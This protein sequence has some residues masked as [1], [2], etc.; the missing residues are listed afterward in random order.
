MTGFID[1]LTHS[2]LRFSFMLYIALLVC[3]EF[4]YRI[5]DHRRRVVPERADEGAGLIVTSILG[6]L[7]FI[8]ALTLSNASTRYSERQS[9]ALIEANAISTAWLQA[10]AVGGERA[11]TLQAALERYME[12]RHDYVSAHRSDPH[13]AEISDET[14]ALQNT[15]WAEL[16]AITVTSAT[17]TVSSLMNA[18]NSAFDASTEMRYAMDY[19]VPYQI[20]L[21]L[22][23]MSLIGVG[24]VGYQ[25]GLL[26]R[27][28]RAPVFLLGAIWCLIVTEILDLGSARMGSFKADTRV[29][30]W[31]MES[32]GID[33]G[34]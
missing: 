22:L 1:F 16:S 14:N 25:F 34:Q 5:G 20:I 15:I 28:G 23:L 12:L 10:G 3:S 33:T 7:A 2:P 31:T 13:I 19:K 18:L 26:K 6:L 21:I 32:M 29:Y 30:D 8:L 27:I 4:G 17:P 9:A 24:C 11:E